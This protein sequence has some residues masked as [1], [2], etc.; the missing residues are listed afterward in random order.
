[1]QT[2]FAASLSGTEKKYVQN[3]CVATTTTA[4]TATTTKPLPCCNLF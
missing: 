1:M 3:R 4:T 2:H